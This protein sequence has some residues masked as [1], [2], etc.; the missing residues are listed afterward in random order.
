MTKFDNLTLVLKEEE[1]KFN[2]PRNIG[3]VYAILQRRTESFDCI[4]Q[5]IVFYDSLHLI[6][7]VITYHSVHLILLIMFGYHIL[8]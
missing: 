5:C 2:C 8:K 1:K 3:F 6:C 4:Q 7:V